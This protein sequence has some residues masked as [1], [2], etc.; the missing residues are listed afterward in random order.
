MK[1]LEKDSVEAK[2]RLKSMSD[3]YALL[4]KNLATYIRKKDGN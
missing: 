1:Q 2:E 3:E 4:R